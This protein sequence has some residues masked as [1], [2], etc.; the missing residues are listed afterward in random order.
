[1]EVP[2]KV[3][4][5][6]DHAKEYAENKLDLIALNVQDK[7]S[8]V[9]SS[10][11]AGLVLGI[12]SILIL[13]FLSIG[14]AW[15]LGQILGSPSI[16]FFCIAGFYILLGIVVYSSREQLIRLPIINF[17]IKKINFNEKN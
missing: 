10:I 8:D 13:M 1:M 11:I 17:L 3:E 5:L 2:S 4:N 16:G 6:I 14:A 7:A 9:V 15:W 12:V